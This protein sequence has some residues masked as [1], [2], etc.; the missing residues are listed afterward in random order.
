MPQIM[1]LQ[2]P[3][4]RDRWRLD[5]VSLLAVIGESS[6]S[7]QVQPLTASRACLLPRLLPAPQALLR[8]SRPSG[9]PSQN[10]IIVGV[11][12]GIMVNQLNYFANLLHPI[13]EL[14]PHTV[15]KISI[16]HK[17][18]RRANNPRFVPRDIVPNTFSPLS[19]LTVFSM[20]LTLGLLV[21]AFIIED[22][23]AFVA[24][25]MISATSSIVGLASLW[26]PQLSK[27][28]LSSRV[29]PGDMVIRTRNAA[30]LIIHCP[31]DIARELYIGA[32]TCA[33][34]VRNRLFQVLMGLGTLLLMMAVALMSN[35]TWDMQLAL[36]ISYI[37][38]NALYWGAAMLPA[39]WHWNLDRYELRLELQ[40]KL[41][42]YTEALW[43]AIKITG[44]DGT[45]YRREGRYS[46]AWVQISAAAPKT[47][48]WNNWLKEAEESVNIGTDEWDAIAAW[49]KLQKEEEVEA[50]AEPADIMRYLKRDT[51]D[52]IPLN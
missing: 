14:A 47:S 44:K 16:T 41:E 36:G 45:G 11:Y 12:S 2:F 37:L 27:R 6:M 19:V 40:V 33:Y 42:S 15:Q 28:G 8:P 48:A 43:Q 13:A 25:L 50:G 24:I 17:I 26:R 39:D 10:A 3:T 20:L 34:S 35:C 31:E 49:Q 1:P 23:V 9:L 30:F 51:V 38:L 7:G 46:A 5:L 18:K 32:E 21:W 4:S 52:D 22:G 29:P